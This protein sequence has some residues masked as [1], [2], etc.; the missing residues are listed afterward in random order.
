VGALV[1]YHGSLAHGRYTIVAHDTPPRHATDGD[2]PDGVAYYLWPEGVAHKFG[3]RHLSISRARR[4]NLTVLAA[5]GITEEA[6]DNP[7]S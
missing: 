2:Y 7:G 3:N 1:E 5:P 6:N 4:P